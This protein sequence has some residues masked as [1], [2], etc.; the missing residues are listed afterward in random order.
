MLN[1]LLKVYNK[2]NFYI[3]V[4]YVWFIIL[5]LYYA[6]FVDLA[7]EFIQELKEYHHMS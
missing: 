4:N 6:S 2:I 7:S 1:N 3:N 5:F